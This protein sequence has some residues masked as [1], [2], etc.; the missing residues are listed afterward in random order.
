MGAYL[1][2]PNVSIT[3]STVSQAALLLHNILTG[4]LSYSKISSFSV[5]IDAQTKA[6]GERLSIRIQ[7]TTE[8][9]AYTPTVRR[10]RRMLGPHPGE[11]LSR[12]HVLTTVYFSP[13][14]GNHLL[15]WHKTPYRVLTTTAIRIVCRSCH[16]C[17]PFY[18]SWIPKTE[19]YL[20]WSEAE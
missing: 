6:S 12:C 17:P 13:I 14:P 20:C 7:C 2:G 1:S 9:L 11:S 18:G 5:M 15:T 10:Q 19:F 16:I 4:H 3:T 8:P